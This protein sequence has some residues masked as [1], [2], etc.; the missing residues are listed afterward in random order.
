MSAFSMNAE[1][2]AIVF[3]FGLTVL[4][5]LMTQFYL[6]PAQRQRSEIQ[7]RL[8]VARAKATVLSAANAMDNIFGQLGSLVFTLNS[9]EQPD[10]NSSEVVRTLQRRALDWRHDGVRTYIAQLGAAGEIDYP[11]ASSTYERLVDDEMR[12]G[13]MAAYRKA[14]TFEADLS[15]KAVQD[16][17]VAAMDAIELHS[18]LLAFDGVVQARKLGL[19]IVTLIGST[20]ILL[21]TLIATSAKPEVSTTPIVIDDN[22]DLSSTIRVLKVALG[23]IS[24]RITEKLNRSSLP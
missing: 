16:G 15:F 12:L 17:G 23:D 20:F 22:A 9:N 2:A 11:T 3:G 10:Q 4:G 24:Q 19:L 13:T 1:R 18:K 5:L 8:A 14:N 21:A 6:E 7:E